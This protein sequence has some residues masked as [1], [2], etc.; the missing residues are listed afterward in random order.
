MVADSGQNI[1][2]VKQTFR[3]EKV[4]IQQSVSSFGA[5]YYLRITI[6]PN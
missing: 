1:T 3:T 5:A 4:N 2:R 6:I